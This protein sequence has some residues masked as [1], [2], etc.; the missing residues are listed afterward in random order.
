VTAFV[1]ASDACVAAAEP[2]NYL[3]LLCGYDGKEDEL[4]KAR[5]GT[6]RVPPHWQPGLDLDLLDE[7]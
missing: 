4:T 7:N 5:L 2:H 6:I 3:D 1:T